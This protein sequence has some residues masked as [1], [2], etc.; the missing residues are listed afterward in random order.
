[1]NDDKTFSTGQWVGKT[2]A[3]KD[4]LKGTLSNEKRLELILFLQSVE[5]VYYQTL[6]IENPKSD[7]HPTHTLFFS[8]KTKRG[9]SYAPPESDTTNPE[10]IPPIYTDDDIPF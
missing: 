2:K 9:G 5:E 7:R 4:T 1:M 8:E 10:R 3:G 6:T